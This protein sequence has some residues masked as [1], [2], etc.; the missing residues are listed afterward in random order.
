MK[1]MIVSDQGEVLDTEELTRIE[2][3]CLTPQGAWALLKGMS[4]GDAK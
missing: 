4:I 1:I 2:W 3:D